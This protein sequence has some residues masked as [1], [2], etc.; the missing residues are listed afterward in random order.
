M[1]SSRSATVEPAVV[2]WVALAVA[3]LGI[4]AYLIRRG[5]R[6]LSE[7]AGLPGGRTVRAVLSAHFDGCL[8]PADPFC[9]AARLIRLH[10]PPPGG[11]VT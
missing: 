9:A 2:A 4:D 10:L 7:V 6:T 1:L 11:S 8:G 5:H 3:A